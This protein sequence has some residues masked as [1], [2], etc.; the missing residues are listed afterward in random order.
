MNNFTD[1]N[2]KENDNKP[3]SP[4]KDSISYLKLLKHLIKKLKTFKCI[5]TYNT[6]NS[7]DPLSTL[8]GAKLGSVNIWKKNL[9]FILEN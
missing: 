4:F 8:I 5:S 9:I 2:K 6:T 1:W 3:I 7:S